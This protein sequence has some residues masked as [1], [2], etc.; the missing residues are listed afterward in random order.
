VL[1][2]ACYIVF[3]MS[4][5]TRWSWYYTSWVLLASLLLARIAE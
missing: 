4:D 2:H 3:R 1:C 5:E